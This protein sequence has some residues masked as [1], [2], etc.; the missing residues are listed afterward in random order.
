[1]PI[2]QKELLSKLAS[3]ESLEDVEIG[4]VDFSGYAF[5]K[6]MNFR[7]AKFTGN[8][9][10]RNT[11]FLDGADFFYAQF[12]G[13]GGAIF[14]SAKFSGKGQTYFDQAKFSGKGGANFYRAEFSGEGLVRFV[15]TQFSGEAGVNFC[16]AQFSAK[17]WVN[18]ARAQFS[19]EGLVSFSGAKF[20]GEG[21][22]N[23]FKAEFSGEQRATFGFAQFSGEGETRFE[24]TQFLGGGGVD[25]R[26]AQFFGERKIVFENTIFKEGCPINFSRV[27]I[28][29][30]QNL[31]FV[32]VDN[33]GGFSF[34]Y[35]D[36]EN[37]VFKNVS[38]LNTKGRFFNREFIGDEVWNDVATEEDKVDFDSTHFHQVEIL[39][40]QLKRN[41]EEQR[42][43]E[44]AGDFHYGEMEMKRKQL[45]RWRQFVSLN[46]LY[47]VISGYGQKWYQGLISFLILSVLF[48][49]PNM[50]WVHPPKETLAQYE[51]GEANSCLAGYEVCP[52]VYWPQT[53]L[54]TLRVMTLN[55]SLNYEPKQAI[56]LGGFA[57]F[58]QYL[59]GPT[60][61]AL[62]VLA[63]RRQFRR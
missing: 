22:V 47:K 15:R 3:G 59:I 8:T 10:F 5:K 32:D 25:F 57:I 17:G 16:N 24:E 14:E 48:S 28:K 63:I 51:M 7:G 49:I 26:Y 33:L 19:G 2:N 12:S 45:P 38:F 39:Y 31:R 52:E 36:V 4:D 30:P 43:Y 62:M 18:F 56:W 37:I 27:K 44:R 40:R 35:T 11:Q 58:L 46:F 29:N 20:S 55:K 13:E 9:V 34:L 41:F 21:V 54:F 60:V 42:D 6:E 61:I 53:F 1:M 50:Y 23:F